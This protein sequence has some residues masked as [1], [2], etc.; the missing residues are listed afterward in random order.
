MCVRVCVF[1]KWPM[2]R[3]L[4]VTVRT[5]TTTVW[6][7]TTSTCANRTSATVSQSVHSNHSFASSS[8]LHS[9]P[10]SSYCMWTVQGRHRL[11]KESVCMC[12]SCSS[13]VN[14]LT[15]TSAIRVYE[16][17]QVWLSVRV[18]GC[19]KLQMTANTVW[20][21]MLYSSCTHMATVGII[22]LSFTQTWLSSVELT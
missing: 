7:P 4:Y 17:N 19:Q 20:H 21:R 22:G 13:L 8:C 2:R 14:P 9:S 16:L 1:R 11:Y 3:T 15:T 10:L 18:P 6:R 5:K 12:L